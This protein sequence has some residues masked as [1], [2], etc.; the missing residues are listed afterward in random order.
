MK[1][2]IFAA[3]A[4]AAI[5]VPLAANAA[6]MAVRRA[7]VYK[8]P[9][10]PVVYSWSGCYIGI[11]GGGGFGHTRWSDPLASPANFVFSSHDTD[12][13][14]AG[15]QVGCDWQNNAFVFGIEGTASW[16]DLTG[17]SLDSLSPGGIT[18]RD[19]TK[20]D[21]I[22]TITGRLGWALDRTLLYVKGGGAVINNQLRVTCDTG[23]GSCAGFPLGTLFASADDSRWGWT[24]GA[25]I[26]Y[27]F[28]NSW[29]G[30]IEY[31]FMDF[32]RDN[33]TFT[34]GPPIAGITPFQFGIDQHVHVI[35]AGLN[36][37]FNW[38]GPVMAAY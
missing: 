13:G 15:G 22:G 25:G 29:S 4:V 36:Y 9:P 2:T 28:A 35:K 1:R 17:D 11:H 20:I 8:A 34:G 10:P 38:G 32:G 24:V 31:N 6:D 16:A 27:A 12:G 23:L 5:T 18:L 33:S 19:H 21:F 14:L 3:A 30:K 37:R 26:E 7:P